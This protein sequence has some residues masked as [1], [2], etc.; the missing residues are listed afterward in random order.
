M[1]FWLPLLTYSLPVA[2][3]AGVGVGVGKGV[4]VGLGVG[5]D[6]GLGLPPRVLRGEMTHPLNIAMES[7]KVKK[8]RLVF[9]G[10]AHHYIN[11]LRMKSCSISD[12][13]AVWDATKTPKLLVKKFTSEHYSCHFKKCDWEIV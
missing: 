11:S 12:S 3:G 5:V 8:Q 1:E 13:G 2:A 6:V 7:T 9:R 10:T 4:G